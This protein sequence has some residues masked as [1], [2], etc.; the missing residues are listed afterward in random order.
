[1]GKEQNIEEVMFYYSPTAAGQEKETSKAIENAL[2]HRGIQPRFSPSKLEKSEFEENYT[3]KRQKYQTS[4]PQVPYSTVEGRIRSL[5]EPPE[6]EWLDWTVLENGGIFIPKDIPD[7]PATL[8][9]YPCFEEESRQ[10][11]KRFQIELMILEALKKRD[12]RNMNQEEQKIYDFWMTIRP[13]EYYRHTSMVTDWIENAAYASLS[14]TWQPS[15][16]KFRSAFTDRFTIPLIQSKI[17]NRLELYES[18]QEAI[19]ITHSLI[20][21]KSFFG[22]NQMYRW[23]DRQWM[24]QNYPITKQMEKEEFKRRIEDPK[25]LVE[26]HT[27]NKVLY[28]MEVKEE[29]EELYQLRLHLAD[30]DIAEEEKEIN[31][32]ENGSDNWRNI[33]GVSPEQ[34]GAKSETWRNTSGMKID[35][36]RKMENP[37]QLPT[38]DEKGNLDRGDRKSVV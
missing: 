28:E 37:K 12:Y 1:M 23:L 2:G 38:S 25:A 22:V 20:V 21:I 3:I 14:T 29:E 27:V 26:E 9:N 11:S 7:F 34:E 24:E 13:G 8:A 18:F 4:A 15:T 35:S 19:R 31:A 10:K 30:E 5:S 17:N 33:S 16:K 36:E 32:S 6:P